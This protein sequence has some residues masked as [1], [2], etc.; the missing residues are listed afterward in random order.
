MEKKNNIFNN[1]NQDN[2]INK[3]KTLSSNLIQIKSQTNNY[4]ANNNGSLTKKAETHFY[5]KINNQIDKPKKYNRQEII[6]NNI[7]KPSK[8]REK[9][10]I[11]FSNSPINISEIKSNNNRLDNRIKN[12]KV[13]KI[14]FDKNVTHHKTNFISNSNNT[15]IN[16]QQ[17]NTIYLT[18]PESI[19]FSNNNS[20]DL[21]YNNTDGN[22]SSLFN[23]YKYNNKTTIVKKKLMKEYPKKKINFKDLK[24]F[25]AH[26]EIFFSLYLKKI[27]K[28]FILKLKLFEEIKNNEKY[29]SEDGLQ[30]KNFRP[31]VN[32]NNAHCALYCSINVN[33]D[34]LINTLLNSNNFS[35]FSNNVS[36]PISKKKE[37]RIQKNVFK[38]NDYNIIKRNKTIFINPIE[39]NFNTGNIP[40]D[41]NQILY[42]TKK[43][44]NK[45]NKDLIN[46]ENKIINN[47]SHINNIK[48]SPIKEMNIN[49]S[50]LNFIKLNDIEKYPLNQTSLNK[51]INFDDNKYK[52]N[53]INRLNNSNT[54]LIHINLERN[55]LKKIKSAKNDIYYKPKENLNKKPIKEI[56]IQNKLTLTNNQ[57]KINNSCY[58]FSKINNNKISKK[59]SERIQNTEQNLIKKIYIKRSSQIPNN[60]NY[61]N[62]SHYNSTFINYKADNEKNINDILLIKEIRTLDN[63]LFINVKYIAI[64]QQNLKNKVIKRYN[65]EN[66]KIIRLYS[67]S[68]INNK[69]TLNKE[70][71]ENLK[72]YN[73][74]SYKGFIDFY[75]FDNDKNKSFKNIINLINIIKNIISTKIFQLLSKKYSK[76]ILLKSLLK[77]NYKRNI[78]TFFFR[79]VNNSGIKNNKNSKG[80]YHKINY[81]DDF[82]TNNRFQTPK[83]GN[84][85]KRVNNSRP[86]NL[87]HKNSNNQINIKKRVIEN[88][89]LKDS[90]INNTYK[91]QKSLYNNKIH[92]ISFNQTK[93][94]INNK[95]K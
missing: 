71:Y 80:I 30:S 66:E 11:I 58:S 10:K 36:T 25:F 46:K 76:K 47:N 26:I 84:K 17:I 67:I 70:L 38:S 49:L 68:I 9:E 81:N 53:L 56:K 63:K 21:Y 95:N 7:K 59:N 1:N 12:I 65:R 3:K 89:S 72:M 57:I 90:F 5:S 61:S 91:T 18:K 40:R 31:I 69:I 73:L 42:M 39:F 83:N 79:F 6:E 8:L 41:K 2:K 34:K 20:I 15:N 45:N 35:S 51:N 13:N 52:V 87:T 44:L 77:K 94:D 4:K 32:V 16:Y 78:K 23:K 14:N 93:T 62:I 54:D 28:S 86:Y 50:Q 29:N 75:F 48:I 55:K 82:N 74:N 60:F 22:D 27:F 43:S 85:F 33:Q 64:N 88:H 92:N 37:S 19:N 24:T